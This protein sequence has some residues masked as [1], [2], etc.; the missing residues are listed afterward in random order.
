[1]RALGIVLLTLLCIFGRFALR[2]R[3]VAR[4]GFGL[5][6]TNVPR[7]LRSG[8][9]NAFVWTLGQV[10]FV[11][12]AVLLFAYFAWYWSLLAIFLAGGLE[13]PLL[14]F[15]CRGDLEAAVRFRQEH[16]ELF[17]ELHRVEG[18]DSL[19]DELD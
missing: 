2:W 18:T 14:L 16:K 10:A 4:T 7:L 1:M 13:R 5:A 8:S 11:G 3:R 12:P 9:A 19:E 17:D 6:V 15:L